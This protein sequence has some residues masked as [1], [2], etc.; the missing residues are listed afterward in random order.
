[1]RLVGIYRVVGLLCDAGLEIDEAD[2]WFV[3]WVW[4]G[5]GGLRRGVGGGIREAAYG[6]ACQVQ[7]TAISSLCCHAKAH[8]DLLDVVGILYD[9]TATMGISNR[10]LFRLIVFTIPRGLYSLFALIFA[11]LAWTL[12]SLLLCCLLWC[13]Q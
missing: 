2:E 9:L 12:V 13:E 1:L 4:G 6:H 7:A 5:F 3:S 10:V 11:L 8:L